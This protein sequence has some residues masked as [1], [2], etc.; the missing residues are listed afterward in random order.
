MGVASVAGYN[1]G[2]YNR[3]HKQGEFTVQ[4]EPL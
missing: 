1:R 4:Y 3:R 2:I